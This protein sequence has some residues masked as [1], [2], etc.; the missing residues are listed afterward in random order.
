MVEDDN[1]KLRPERVEIFKMLSE[2]VCVEM[3]V[4]ICIDR[5]VITGI[6]KEKFLIYFLSESHS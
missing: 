4:E 1:G 2:N 3:I 6:L 5:W